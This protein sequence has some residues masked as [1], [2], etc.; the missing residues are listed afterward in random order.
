MLGL[1]GASRLEGAPELETAGGRICT[2]V[3]QPTQLVVQV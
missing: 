1:D 2:R 3:C